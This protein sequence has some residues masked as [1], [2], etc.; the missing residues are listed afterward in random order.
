MLFASLTIYLLFSGIKEK[1]FDLEILTDIYLIYL[2]TGF[3]MLCVLFYTGSPIITVVTLLNIIFSLSVSYFIYT[4]VLDMKFFPFLNVL[5]IIVLIGISADSSFIMY[6]AWKV[7][8]IDDQTDSVLADMMAKTLKHSLLSISVSTTTTFC[9]FAS[10]LFGAI[11]GISCFRY[12]FIKISVKR[13]YR[14]LTFFF[15]F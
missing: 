15:L 11:S 9:A 5:A 12:D 1:L 8:K 3:I 7:I 4:F 14:I 13:M 10:S 2:S 6:D